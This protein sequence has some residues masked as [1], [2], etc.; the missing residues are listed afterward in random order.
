VGSL[1]MLEYDSGVDEGVVDGASSVDGDFSLEFSGVVV[2]VAA[3]RYEPTVG[4]NKSG[5]EPKTSPKSEL[6]SR[7][8]MDGVCRS[9]TCSLNPAHGSGVLSWSSKRAE[10]LQQPI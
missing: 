7:S 8:V 4:D 2:Y 9:K 1:E 5:G 3:E 10:L 6:T